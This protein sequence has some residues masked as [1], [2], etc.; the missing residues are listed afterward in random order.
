VGKKGLTVIAKPVQPMERA[1]CW[2]TEVDTDRPLPCA[3]LHI[4][5]MSVLRSHGLFER[6]HNVVL[7]SSGV[8][9]LPW[10][11]ALRNASCG[12]AL[13]HDS[14]ALCLTSQQKWARTAMRMS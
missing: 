4:P 6:Y 1:P 14:Y 7:C 5:P 8:H 12:H 9:E 10:I 3:S 2:V 13:D 11:A